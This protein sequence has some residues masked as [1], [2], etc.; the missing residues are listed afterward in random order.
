MFQAFLTSF[1]K[2]SYYKIQEK[3]PCVYFISN[4]TSQKGYSPIYSIIRREVFPSKKDP[5]NLYLSYK[6]NLDFKDC[7][8]RKKVKPI[9]LENSYLDTW[10]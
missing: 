10:G 8:M 1:E 5:K 4:A 6:T 9:S 2:K 7:F 3:Q